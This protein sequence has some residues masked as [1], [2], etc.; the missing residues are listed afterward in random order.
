MGIRNLVYLRPLDNANT[1]RALEFEVM[2]SN[3]ENIT[4]VKG[5]LV[6]YGVQLVYLSSPDR[7]VR[8]IVDD[9]SFIPRPVS[10]YDCRAI[11]LSYSFLS[12]VFHQGNCSVFDVV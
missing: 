2:W 4:L 11:S 9:T 6:E 8:M 3:P 12:E 1:I 7:I 5:L 10:A